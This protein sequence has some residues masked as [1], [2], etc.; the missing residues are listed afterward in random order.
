MWTTLLPVARV[1]A[2]SGG[3]FVWCVWFSV[4]A[5]PRQWHGFDLVRHPPI[6]LLHHR[7]S[8]SMDS[9]IQ[10]LMYQPPLSATL[11]LGFA[12]VRAKSGQT[13]EGIIWM[14]SNAELLPAAFLGEDQTTI[15]RGVGACM[16]LPLKQGG[17]LACC[18]RP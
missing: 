12:L 3:S 15:F 6:L 10:S 13:G 1:S 4:G 18:P 14:D 7:P 17:G 2:C 5:Q 16:G 11:N 9:Q 8:L